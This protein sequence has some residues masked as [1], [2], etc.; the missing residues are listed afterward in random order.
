[1]CTCGCDIYS[2]F[3]MYIWLCA[4]C[5]YVCM[6][7]HFPQY[8]SAWRQQASKNA[9][10]FPFI[11]HIKRKILCIVYINQ[12]NRAERPALNFDRL[13]CLFQ[14]FVIM[15]SFVEQW[16][17]MPLSVLRPVVYN[18]TLGD[19]MIREHIDQIFRFISLPLS[20]FRSRFRCGCSRP[21]RTTS[22]KNFKIYNIYIYK[23]L[24]KSI[25]VCN[26][27]H[28]TNSISRLHFLSSSFERDIL[29]THRIHWQNEQK[30]KNCVPLNHEL[31]KKKKTH[32]YI[33]I[34]A[35]Y[36]TTF[37]WKWM[38]QWEIRP[39]IT[40]LLNK[41]P[42]LNSWMCAAALSHTAQQS[43]RVCHTTSESSC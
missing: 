20:C 36:Y 13:C 3:Y 16:W 10:C 12:M 39:I 38:K 15:K 8:G 22:I 28:Y 7:S 5:I 33:V 31:M 37:Q 27:N 18:F 6:S 21:F 17:Y 1:M 30:K 9:A 24:L 14:P 19:R 32:K 25:F 43:H 29:F 4:V 42:M 26:R 40:T 11:S 23:R 35:M 34:F 41:M 2:V